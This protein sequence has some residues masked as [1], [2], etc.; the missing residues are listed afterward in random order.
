MNAVLRST[1]R[2]TTRRVLASFALCAAVAAAQNVVDVTLTAAPSVVSLGAGSVGNAWTYDGLYPGPALVANAGDTLRVRFI[3]NLSV[4]TLVHWHGI[5]APLGMDGVPGIS[6]P[7]VAPGQ[8]FTYVLPNLPAGTY[9]YHSH[10][11]TQ[12]EAGL[13]GPLIV[14]AAPGDDPPA[15]VEH[16]VFLDRWSNVLPGATPAYVG[17]TINGRRSDGQVPFVVTTGQTARFRFINGSNIHNYYVA[18]DQHP[19]TV[20]HADGNRIQPVVVQALPIGT[21]ERWDA[22]VAC[23]NPGRWSVAAAQ[24]PFRTTTVVRGILEYAGSTA[25]TPAANF[26]P[27]FLATGSLL[28]YAQLASFA[29][30]PPIDPAPERS[31]VLALS[32]SPTTFQWLIN[33]EAWPNVTPMQ[34][35]FGDDVQMTLQNATTLHHPFH[36]HCHYFRLLGT[37][38][39]TTNAPLKDTILIDPSGQPGATRTVQVLAD[40]PGS[41]LVHCHHLAH[42]DT[43]MMT[44][45]DYVGDFDADGVPDAFDMDSASPYP[46]VTIPS[47]SSSFDL[48][49]TTP[50]SIQWAPGETVGLYFGAP[51]A[52][53]AGPTDLGPAGVLYIDPQFGVFEIGAA[54]VGMNTYATLYGSIPNLPSLHGFKVLLQGVGTSVLAPGIRLST[55][56]TLTIN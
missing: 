20:T 43:G 34:A 13:K 24:I 52:A 38:G 9:W 5:P 46:V 36:V 6:R 42:Q 31:Y 35:A 25:P 12:I 56:Q 26:N 47:T 18:I 33:G 7:A 10:V 17:H 50:L 45:L 19:L 2:P 14:H 39:G 29:P 53:P 28:S 30:T 51:F 22:L 41:W 3:N 54:T 1:P 55:A 4:E 40:H 16:V 49:A 32:Q 48:G 21:G 27:P 37:A 44:L 23:N 15:D 11:G 8:E